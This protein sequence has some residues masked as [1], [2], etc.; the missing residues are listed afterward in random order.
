[1]SRDH[2]KCWLCMTVFFIRKIQGERLMANLTL[3]FLHQHSLRKNPSERVSLISRFESGHRFWKHDFKL[4]KFL[5]PVSFMASL[6]YPA[7]LNW[8][9]KV[10]LIWT[11][12][13]IFRQIIDK[14]FMKLK[15]S[16][17]FFRVS[18]MYA[19]TLWSQIFIIFLQS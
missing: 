2:L 8:L 12:F 18:Y 1:M 13:V 16:R 11:I 3:I 9:I 15:L 10:V 4:S 7:S 14:S 5:C 6:R 19:R 17:K